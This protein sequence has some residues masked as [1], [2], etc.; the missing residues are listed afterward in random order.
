MAAAALSL[1]ACSELPDAINPVSWYESLAD[2]IEDDEVIF[3]EGE[4]VLGAEEAAIVGA[5][6][7]FPTLA[8]VPDAPR[9]VTSPDEF[10]D[11]AAGLIADRDQARYTDETLRSQY[12][13]STESELEVVPFQPEDTGQAP[14]AVEIEPLR[15]IRDEPDHAAAAPEAMLDSAGQLAERRRVDGEAVALAPQSDLTAAERLAE[16]RRIQSIA[17]A[18]EAVLAAREIPQAERQGFTTAATLS[19]NRRI[20]AETQTRLDLLEA[21]QSISAADRAGPADM[22]VNADEAVPVPI[23]TET[24]RLEPVRAVTVSAA[25]LG[26]TDFKSAFNA[27]FEASGRPAVAEVM[28][29]QRADRQRS[30]VAV[31]NA[32]M[33]STSAL[34]EP[35]LGTTQGTTLPV[36]TDR[37][38][39]AEISPNQVP[40]QSQISFLAGTISFPAGSAELSKEGRTHLKRIVQLHGKYGGQIRVVGHASRRTRD[41]DLGR[42]QLVNFRLSVDRANAVAVALA[43]LGVAYEALQIVA[44]SDTMPLAYEYMP[45]G[46]AEN[47]RAEIFIEY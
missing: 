37:I 43:R 12:E 6:E 15:K 42:H 10:D 28:A 18:S 26:A 39:L 35:A 4:S 5:S 36:T 31:S 33:P 45:A 44:A 11:L 47:R 46:E 1:A 38:M 25:P 21:E 2:L 41:M 14:P 20:K 9:E 29:R 30:A 7:D 23:T 8:E 22:R 19:D 16:E 27:Q 40:V 32:D 13:T 34:L 24:K 3:A 17:P